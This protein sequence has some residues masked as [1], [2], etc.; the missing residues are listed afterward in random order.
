MLQNPVP[1]RRIS[2]ARGIIL[3]TTPTSIVIPLFVP[4][5]SRVL[6]G[7]LGV[8]T[9]GVRRML[10]VREEPLVRPTLPATR[11]P[12]P[13]PP[14]SNAKQRRFAIKKASYDL[15]QPRC[16]AATSF[17]EQHYSRDLPPF[18]SLM[19]HAQP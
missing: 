14:I 13:N 2:P 12:A 9:L 11:T 5:T 10:I 18:L 3:C 19:L 4:D 8:F 17:K 1:V 7:V 15:N 6:N 16:A